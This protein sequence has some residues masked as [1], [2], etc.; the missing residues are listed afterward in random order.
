MEVDF[1]KVLDLW[2]CLEWRI[3]L[4]NVDDMWLWLKLRDVGSLQ[5]R[6]FLAM[7][8]TCVDVVCVYVFTRCLA[9]PSLHTFPKILPM[10]WETAQ[11]E[12][13][14]SCLHGRQ[15]CHHLI[16]LSSSI[17]AMW[18]FSFVHAP[19]DMEAVEESEE[20]GEMEEEK[21]EAPA[22][23]RRQ[24]EKSTRGEQGGGGGGGA[25]SSDALPDILLW[26]F[27]NGAPPT[28]QMFEVDA[29]DTIRTLKA[30]I[31]D[32]LCVFI[33]KQVL[34]HGC[35]KLNDS[36][37]IADLGLPVTLYFVRKHSM[38]EEEIFSGCIASASDEELDKEPDEDLARRQRFHAW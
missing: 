1:C 4:G 11:E 37:A 19:W 18:P 24:E 34:V 8:V 22:Q 21:E 35:K 33:R 2:L 23:E 15:G 5:M 29:R 12:L 30:N 13:R 25:A 7:I 10:D 3:D 16:L 38:E 31:Q 17:V 27:I 26:D 14:A 36:R 6:F 20:Y 28:R 9:V 32:R